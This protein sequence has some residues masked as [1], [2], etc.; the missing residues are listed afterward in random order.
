[1]ALPDEALEKLRQLRKADLAKRG[2]DVG[3]VWQI[4]HYL[5]AYVVQAK[6]R[7]VLVAAVIGPNEERA[8]AL[9]IEGTSQPQKLAAPLCLTLLAGEA[10]VRI[11]THFPFLPPR[12]QQLAVDTLVRECEF[13]GELSED[14]LADLDAAIAASRIVVLRRARGLSAR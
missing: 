1:V 13:W 4:P 10:G 9:A 7:P 12:L 8:R 2:S 14:R 5:V 11:D 3:E 6:S